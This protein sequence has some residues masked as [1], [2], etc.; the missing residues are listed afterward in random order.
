MFQPT[1]SSQVRDNSKLMT[2]RKSL[3]T[4]NNDGMFSLT[5]LTYVQI[6]RNTSTSKRVLEH[7]RPQ[8]PLKPQW[9]HNDGHPMLLEL[10]ACFGYLLE[11][12]PFGKKQAKCWASCKG[13]NGRTHFGERYYSACCH[14]RAAEGLPLDSSSRFYLPIR[15]E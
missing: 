4:E 5:T 9:I 15:R 8:N 14:H 6:S 10:P 1:E 7:I 2:Y 13:K 12:S 11:F 3:E